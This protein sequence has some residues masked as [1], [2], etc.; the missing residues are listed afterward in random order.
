MVWVIDTRCLCSVCL[1]PLTRGGPGVFPVCSDDEITVGKFY[2]TFL[3]QDYFRKF[4]RRKE[5]GLV[6]RHPWDGLN[7]TM[8]LQVGGLPAL[9]VG[10]AASLLSG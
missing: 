4:K 10:S 7:N 3:I 5:Q 6:G 2:A 9:T 1:R 8:A